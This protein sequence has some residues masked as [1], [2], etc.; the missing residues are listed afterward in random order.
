MNFFNAQDLAHR[1]T[2]RLVFVY[3]L[4]AASIVIGVTLVVGLAL[5]IGSDA[6]NVT[7]IPAHF[8]ELAPFLIGVAIA[9]TLFIGGASLVKT[10]KLSSGGGRVAEDLGATL[11]PAN[12]QDPLHR[13]LRNVVE[14]MAIASGV[15]VPAIYVLEK[16]AGI[17]AFA[18][19]YRPEDAAIAVT[20]GTLEL[21]D[22]DELQ[23][24]IGHEFSHILNG[25]MRLNI[26]L[27]GVLFGIMV[28]GLIGRTVLHG[29]RHTRGR[30]A[31]VGLAVGL[32]FAILG[33]I[34]VLFSRI[35]KASI[36]RQREYLADASA[37][38]FT[39]QTSGIAN[40]LKKIGGY[41]AGSHLQVADPEE[42]S[43]M[44]FG[45]GAK[46]S[47]VF[48]THPPLTERIQALDPSFKTSDYPTVDRRSSGVA[49]KSAAPAPRHAGTTSAIAGVTAGLSPEVVTANVAH[50]DKRQID[51]AIQL[52][53][54]FPELLYDA[55]HSSELAYLLPIAL[56]LDPSG[57]VL[58]R[59]LS[60]ARKLLG[61]QR[62]GI[63]EQYY[64][65][66]AKIDAAYR[67][68]LLAVAFP[69]LRRRPPPELEYLIDLTRRM[70][71]I[72]GETDLYEYCFYR[73]LVSSLAN[74][75][76]P[77]RKPKQRRATRKPVREAA[78]DLLRIVAQHG[79][80][81]DDAGEAAFRAGLKIFGNW[82]SAAPY[83]SRRE[84]SAAVLDRHLDMLVAL[85]GEGRQMLIKAISAVII[86]DGKLTTTEVELMRAICASL[87]CPLP[88]I[89]IDKSAS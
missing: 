28:L 39:R 73:L 83:D 89:L 19:G 46:L 75:I 18:A 85:N 2:R 82:A 61:E 23:G 80:Q 27:M 7:S 11:V 15:P 63:I 10:A 72:D 4:A 13:R 9:V 40:A 78:V 34:G 48:A 66:L 49:R 6:K 84:F 42:V 51:Y 74:A 76:D 21:L 81:N 37:V 1:S 17:N 56:I 68:P 57:R 60:L 8:A 3:L 64:D 25:D 62:A 79:H 52:R 53:Q 65:A 5:Y 45:T 31:A 43:H 71:D 47:S 69:A 86:S 44:L 32:G 26:R 33:G 59:Q 16:E 58:G 12:V 22:R 70:I 29:M 77:S 20:R 38:Q 50:P 55:A 54:T 14:E 24:V 30:G 35:I 88:P 36:S 41:S 67:L 87:E